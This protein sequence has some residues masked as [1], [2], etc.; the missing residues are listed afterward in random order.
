MSLGSHVMSK[1]THILECF[2]F[3]DS[4]VIF[5]FFGTI[6]ISSVFWS[7]HILVCFYLVAH[8][9]RTHKSMRFGGPAALVGRGTADAAAGTTTGVTAAAG[10]T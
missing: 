6:F 3:R 9:T 10:A 5:L 8:V 7:S 2:H 1:I 4:L